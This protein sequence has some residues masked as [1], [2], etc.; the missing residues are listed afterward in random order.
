MLVLSPFADM[1]HAS[2][3]SWF[4]Q[5][6]KRA[7]ADTTYVVWVL[8]HWKLTKPPTTTHDRPQMK[9]M[10]AQMTMKALKQT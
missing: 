8:G 4:T 5:N 9:K 1:L 3:I 10:P 7:S 6:S 2:H